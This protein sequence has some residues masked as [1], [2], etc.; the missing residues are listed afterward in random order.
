VYIELFVVSGQSS[1]LEGAL[2]KAV[3]E[4]RGKVQRPDKVRL[5]TVKI[6]PDAV[7]QVLKLLGEPPDKVPPHYRSLVNM[8]K[9]YGVSKFPAVVIDG[10][11]VGEGE[12]SVDE[13]LRVVYERA[14]A[15]FPE[16]AGVELAP[17]RPAAAEAP[18][19]LPPVEAKPV[20]APPPAKP[21]AGEVVPVVPPPPPPSPPPPPPPP[22]PVV[23]AEPPK[24]VELLP[25]ARPPIVEVA[26]AR[27]APGR[28]T[29]V[30]KVVL[31]RP[32]NCSECAYYGP[33]TGRCF[34]FGFAVAD[35]SRPPCKQYARGGG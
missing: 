15:E 31:G 25:P 2:K 32:D 24:P 16:L 9:K 12:I 28:I 7:E 26:P 6:R 29:A 14:R 33:M 30:V 3:E 5:A 34:L 35:P 20:E 21:P 4:I 11:K 17:P 13:V 22:P 10:V 23:P 18:K 8:L 27:P 1:D 19:P